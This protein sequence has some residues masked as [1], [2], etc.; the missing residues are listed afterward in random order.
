MA[1]KLN[2]DAREPEDRALLL[3]AEV[4]QAGGV[5]VYPT[6]TLY[7]LGA[8]AWNPE[9]VTAGTRP[10]KENGG[11]ARSRDRAQRGGGSRAHR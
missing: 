3:A 4:V 9:A 8:N 5:V 6:E 7:G 1:L 11:E 2:V 10:E